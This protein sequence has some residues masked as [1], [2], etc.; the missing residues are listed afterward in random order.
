MDRNEE[1]KFS[2]EAGNDPK[3]F[4]DGIRKERHD[5]SFPLVVE[6]IKG[7]NQVIRATRAK[8]KKHR[9]K[10]FWLSISFL[11]IS[12]IVS[13]TYRVERVEKSGSL[14]NFG[15]DKA[16]KS[17]FQRLSSLQRSFAFT[18]HEFSQPGEPAIAWFI[19]FIPGNEQQK[20]MSI[21]RELRSLEGLRKLDV[22]PVSYNIKE[23]L[24]LTF[25]HKALKLGKQEKLKGK[26]LAVHV[27]AELDKKGLGFVSTRAL[28]D[29][30]DNV[31]FT[32]ADQSLFTKKPGSDT[33]SVRANTSTTES[34]KLQTRGT[35]RS[36]KE[37]LQMFNWLLG[38]WGV[39][40][41]PQPTYHYW[42]RMNDSSLMCFIIKF[43][44]HE[45]AVS[46]G[47]SINYSVAD[48]AILS[49]RG[50]EWKFLSANNRE[51]NFKNETTPKSANVKWSLDN[52]GET[53]QC[54][55][56]GER[57][58]EIVNLVRIEDARL[59]KIVKAFI[60]KKSDKIKL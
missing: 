33:L 56:Y 48:S 36:P 44:D 30:D 42:K 25:L 51:V 17:S 40:Y 50:I 4:W 23:S 29:N 8:K 31:S 55:I 7:T 19:F 27:Q 47:F 21:M 26:N 60:S 1:N 28:N 46:I 15:I 18:S 9:R 6:W 5:Q 52:G 57:N 16:D 14:V 20:L 41:V 53:W 39:I 54:V 35:L 32:P 13:C 37:K 11:F 38:T 49:L 59:E 12:F 43:E 58:K 45:P 34:T 10:L 24:F 22:S 3:L 2:G